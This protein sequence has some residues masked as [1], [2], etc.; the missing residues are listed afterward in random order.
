MQSFDTLSPPFDRLTH[1]E[2]EGLKRCTDIGYFRPGQPIVS[3]GQS[4]KYLHVLIKGVVE[5]REGASLHAVLGPGDTFD[6]RAVVHNE[7]GEDFV[8]AEETLCFLLPRDH[9]LKLV[10]QNQ[11]F[12]AFFY[13]ELSQKLDALAAPRDT[14]GMDSVLS[15]RIRNVRYGAAV[16][17]NG[18]DS[19]EQAAHAMLDADIDALYVNDDD[20]VGVVTGLKLT[21]ASVIQRLPL[22]TPV[23]EIAQFEVVSIDADDLVVDALLIMTRCNKRRIAVRADGN[24]IGVLRDLDILGLFAGNSQLIPGR[25]AR[26][27]SIE[28]LSKAAHDIQEQVERLHRQG[29]RIDV[30][31]SFTSDLNNRLHAKLFEIVAPPSIR[32]AGCL[33]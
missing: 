13:A 12:A 9:I 33:M 19:L 23:R 6:A 7:A 5:V 17:V 26:A 28:D 4:S 11:A 25:I 2:A 10:H 30:I 21:R 32:E 29:V 1:D 27:T 20:R 3:Q 16:F 15:T 24:Y 18:G 22:N 14:R 8:A 31:A